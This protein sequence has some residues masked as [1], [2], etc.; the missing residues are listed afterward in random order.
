MATGQATLRE[1]FK[2]AS[3]KVPAPANFLLQRLR[4][5]IART[6]QNKLP[7]NLAGVKSKPS[8]FEGFIGSVL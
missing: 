5:N 3:N 7:S 2:G 8:S 4:L 1:F 6:I